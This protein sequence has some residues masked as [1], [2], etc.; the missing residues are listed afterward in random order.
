MSTEVYRIDG[1]WP[2]RL[3][4]S[5]RPRG[6]DWLAD[7]VKGWRQAGFDIIVSLLTPDEADEMELGMEQRYSREH[8]LEF[9]SFPI[10]DRSVPES[11][12]AAL[13]LIEHLEAEL[14]RGK[15][16]NIHC[17]QGI[18]RSA[19]IAAGLLLARG[20][21]K[22]EA[23]QRISSSRH[24]PVPETPEQRQWIESVASSLTP[25]SKSSS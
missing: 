18:G 15:N 13:K 16:I 10:V 3:A 4:I 12:A 2:G 24:A 6:G 19:L 1:P 7:E 21:P 22:E 17:R 23:L 25:V 20:V 14:A 9:V 11:R 8:E 5:A